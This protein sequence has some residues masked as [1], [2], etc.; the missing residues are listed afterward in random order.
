MGGGAELG[1]GVEPGRKQEYRA[2]V[3]S[4][5]RL[6]WVVVSSLSLLSLGLGACGSSED[7]GTGS[8]GGIASGGAA[9]GGMGSGGAPLGSGG[10]AAGGLSE[11]GGASTGGSAS[12]GTSSGGAANG[13]GGESAGG[14]GTGGDGSGGSPAEPAEIANSSGVV[15]FTWPGRT[16]VVDGTRGARIISLKS[17]GNEFLSLAPSEDPSGDDLFKYGSTFWT[18]PQSDWS[19]PPVVAID[20]AAYTV[21][22]D[23]GT[24]TFTSSSA[25][26]AEGKEVRIKKAFSVDTSKDIITIVYTIENVGSASASFA[27]WE[28]TRVPKSGLTFFPTGESASTPTG[29]AMLPVTSAGGI[30][31]FQHP[32]MA[33]QDDRK[34]HADGKEGWLAHAT[35]IVTLIKSFADLPNGEAA[36]TEGEVEIYSAKDGTYVEVENQ[37]AYKEL[38]ADASLTYEVRWLLRETPED[39]TVTAGDASLASFVRAELSEAGL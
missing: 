14:S 33:V 6:S 2:R 13:T 10:A 12:G 17:G 11:S 26:V 31:W 5:R 9:A 4:M 35:P 39:V 30:T 16:L 32:G 27:A 34:I 15:T 22:V 38:A 7:P 1:S 8:G 3:A 29:M 36:P 37:G 21:T 23:E 20:S 25:T 24:A 18:S 28:I 19:W